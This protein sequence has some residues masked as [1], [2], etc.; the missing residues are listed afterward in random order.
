MGDADQAHREE[1]E[2]D[3]LALEMCDLIEAEQRY[4]WIKGQDIPNPYLW[5]GA[6]GILLLSS[7]EVFRKVKD[8]IYAN[9]V[10]DTHPDFLD[11]SMSI[12]NRNI[13]QPTMYGTSRD[14]C[15]AVENVLRC[16][17]D[18]LE[19]MM[20]QLLPKNIRDIAPDDW[21]VKSFE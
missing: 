17:M 18:E 14:F 7:L 15:D 5:T 1:F 21:E 3:S 12:K 4:T 19:P 13:M 2:A 20:G 16:V 8:S 11:R 9:K 10:Y 6:G